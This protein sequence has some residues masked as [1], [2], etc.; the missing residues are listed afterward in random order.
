MSPRLK[1][2]RSP[3][4]LGAGVGASAAWPPRRNPRRPSTSA[5]AAFASASVRTRMWRA[6]TSS[7][8]W[9][10]PRF[11]VVAGAQ[12]R[13]GDA[14]RDLAGQEGLLQLLVL[15]AAMRRRT[16]SSLS[17]PAAAGGAG[18]DALGDGALD[19]RS[20]GGDT[21]SGRRQAAHARPAGRPGPRRQDV[22]QADRLAIDPGEDRVPRPGRRSAAGAAS[23][24]CGGGGAAPWAS[25]AVRQA[26]AR[27][28]CGRRAP[29]R[30]I[31]QRMP[32]GRARRAGAGSARRQG[33]GALPAP[34]LTKRGPR[35]VSAAA[36]HGVAV[37]EPGSPC[38]PR[39]A[40]RHRPSAR[41]GIP[42]KQAR[43]FATHRPRHL[44]HR[45]RPG[46]QALQA[47]CRRSTRWSPD[48]CPVG[49]GAAGQT[50]DFR[51]RLA[52]GDRSTT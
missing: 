33:A 26:A 40:R 4:V 6:R 16:A 44:R 28:T 49:R 11:L 51:A 2:P 10:L 24:P 27:R 9:R 45:Q 14:G 1:K 50:A 41:A 48:C 15:G 39:A 31:G 42:E 43:M 36:Q 13:V 35:L 8:P 22:G 32:A 20:I 25:T 29:E 12:R 23:A 38:P 46:A 30:R 3:P 7:S 5:S 21:A 18:Q 19:P 17:R 37:C 34:P 47:A 52:E